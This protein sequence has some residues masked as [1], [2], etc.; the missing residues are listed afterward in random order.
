MNEAPCP[1]TPRVDA[2]D[3]VCG[4]PMFAADDARQDLLHAAFAVST[5]AKGRI[6]H[7]DT[8]AAQAVRGVQLVLSHETIGVVKSGGFIMGGGY[9]FQSFQPMLS[10]A[11]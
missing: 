5:I 10:P 3:K 8:R 6:T 9:G 4:K 2:Y 1:D 11:V 7:L